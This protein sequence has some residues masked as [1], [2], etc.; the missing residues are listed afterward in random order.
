MTAH[1]TP[2][3]PRAKRLLGGWVEAGECLG[4]QIYA[5]IDGHAMADFAVGYSAPGRQATCDDVAR[6]WCA[7][8]PLTACCLARAVESGEAS[9]DDTVSRFLPEFTA[10][11]RAAIT[12]R[13]L[14]SHTSGMFDHGTVL[15]RRG[16]HDVAR[17][18]TRYNA[19]EHAWYR[20]PRYNDLLSWSVLG[21][22]VERIYG[23]AFADVVRDVIARPLGLDSLSML[24]PD[25]S[26][27]APTY[28][29]RGGKF[30][31]LPEMS[32]AV[33]ADMVSP[34]NG[35]YAT[36][37]D[38][39]RLYT[40]L[41]RCAVG[42]GILLTQRTTAQLITQHGV[43]GFGG[44]NELRAYGLGFLLDINT[45]AMGGEWSS[46]TF[47]HSGCVGSARVIY[48]FGDVINDA[49]IAIRLFS[50]GAKNTWRFRQLSEA[51]WRDLWGT[52]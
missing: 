3:M 41:T 26:Q 20:E 18:A 48:A 38:L 46:S 6:L 49:A 1:D 39:G 33:N 16:F 36:M 22:V 28:V 32:D 44:W 35:G 24:Q 30:T 21:V 2:M 19:P 12:L 50:V 4:A 23:R 25:P 29:I 8:K 43:I 47:G 10:Q 37:R 9:F 17:I 45:D 13:Q 40:E 5:A 31:A 7:V 27:Y 15:T 34:A 11:R 14:L 51:I 52:T 42:R